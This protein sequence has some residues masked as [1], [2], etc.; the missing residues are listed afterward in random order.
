MDYQVHNSLLHRRFS[1]NRGTVV[2]KIVIPPTFLP[3]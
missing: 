2:W 3:T 1:Y